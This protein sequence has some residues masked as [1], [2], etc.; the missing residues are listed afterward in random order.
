MASFRGI[1]NILIL[2]GG[3]RNQG[4]PAHGNDNVSP[5]E[6]PLRYT[7]VQDPEVV[8]IGIIDF[9]EEGKA[10]NIGRLLR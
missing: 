6:R 1:T 2:P 4:L 3:S 10:E 8:A 5:T 9:K 7:R